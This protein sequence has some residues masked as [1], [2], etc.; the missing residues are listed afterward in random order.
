MAQL[1]IIDGPIIRAGESLSEIANF[2]A[3][4]PVR[5]VMPTAWD[6]APL[7]FMVSVDGIHFDSLFHSDGKEIALV[8]DGLGRAVSLSGESAIAVSYVK[9]RSGTSMWPVPQSAD[10][11]FL[12]VLDNSVTV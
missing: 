6:T 9:F 10:R 4:R 5:I 12:T 1:V 7:T 3:G 2:T 8:C 11:L